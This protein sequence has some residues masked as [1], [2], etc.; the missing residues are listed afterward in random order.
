MKHFQ[1]VLSETVRKLTSSKQTPHKNIRNHVQITTTNVVALGLGN[2]FVLIPRNG[3]GTSPGSLVHVIHDRSYWDS[4]WY[5][6][7]KRHDVIDNQ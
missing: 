2:P 7:Q 6:N 5:T 4:C 1:P 3:E